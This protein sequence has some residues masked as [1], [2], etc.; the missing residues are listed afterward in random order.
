MELKFRAWWIDAEEYVKVSGI[1][2]INE[3]IHMTE[4]Y[5]NGTY[6]I[7][8]IPFDEVIIEQ[9]TGL[10]DKNGKEI[11]VGDIVEYDFNNEV[12][13]CK[14]DLYGVYFEREDGDTFGTTEDMLKELRVI[15]NIHENKELLK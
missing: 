8:E 9:Y 14:F 10:K 2:F 7:D 11:Y 1:D 15:G 5:K 3:E 13:V 6:S 4:E 12:G